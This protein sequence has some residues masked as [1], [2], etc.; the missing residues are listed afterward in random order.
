MI[1]VGGPVCRPGNHR[2]R[3][4]VQKIPLDFLLLETDCPDQPPD[5]FQGTL[6]P[7]ISLLDV[8][9]SVAEIK[10]LDWSFVLESSRSNFCRL[11]GKK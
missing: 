10:Q 1:S 4:A 11:V 6:N 9:R 2:L 3:E 7:L 8:A 5:P